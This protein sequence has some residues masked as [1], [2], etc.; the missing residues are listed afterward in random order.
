MNTVVLRTDTSGRPTFREL[1]TRVWDTDLS[2]F[3]NQDLPFERLVELL[4]PERSRARHPLF[5]TLLTLRDIEDIRIDLPG[6]TVA[7][8]EIA[9]RTTTCD[10][11]FELVET[12]DG[13]EGLLDYSTDL[14]DAATAEWIAASFTRLLAKL[15][16]APDQPID[17]HCVLSPLERRRVL[18]RYNDTA[19]DVPTGTLTELFAAAVAWVPDVIAVSFEGTDISYA[20]VNQ[21]ANRL[22]HELIARGVGPEDLIALSLPRSVELLV[23]ILAVSKSGAA[24]LPVDPSYPGLSWCYAGLL[25]HLHADQPLYGLQSSAVSL[26]GAVPSTMDDLVSGYVKQVRS[27]QP[28]GPYQLLGWSFGGNVAHALAVR[29]R[30]MGEDVALL[31]IIDAYPSHHSLD[32]LEVPGEQELLEMVRE[33]DGVEPDEQM[34]ARIRRAYA[35]HVDMLRGAVIDVFDGPI[36]HFTAV[37]DRAPQAPDSNSWRHHVTG[38]I[39]RHDVDSTHN[40]MTQPRPLAAIGE[41]IAGKLAEIANGVA[42]Q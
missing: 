16:D 9:T 14:F 42:T 32:G 40:A 18:T 26:D 22:A 31:A 13:I 20:D 7:A 17:R 38:R 19:Q 21:R 3:T 29:L 10:L 2:A 4:N 30:A 37:H 35:A 11:A 28:D 36:V 33:M 15:A 8:E 27:V 25:A 23:A 6:L 5:Q 12:G 39:E 1:L 41:V 24:Y 34:I